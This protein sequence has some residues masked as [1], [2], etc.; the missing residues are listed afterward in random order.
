VSKHDVYST[1]RIL[2]VTSVTIE[3][4]YGYGHLKEIIVRRPNQKLYKFM[5]GEFPRLHLNDIKYMLFL[6]AQNKLN[7]LEDNVIIHLVVGLRMYTQRIVIQSR[8]KDL[9]L[10]VD[11]YQKKLNISNLRTRDVDLSHKAPYTTLSEPQ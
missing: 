9:Q 8:V 3:E 5:E 4:W 7:N 1:M 6:I 11:S 10:G 2:S